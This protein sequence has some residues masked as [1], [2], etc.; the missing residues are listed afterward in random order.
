MVTGVTGKEAKEWAQSTFAATAARCT[1]RSSGRD[2]DE[3]DY[4]A[5]RALVRHVLA[6]STRT[7]SG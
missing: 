5:L 7:A 1:P 3:I 6:T 2:G 4:Q